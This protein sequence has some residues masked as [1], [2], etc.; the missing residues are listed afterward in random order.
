MSA[1]QIVWFKRDLRTVDHRPLMEAIK[2]GPVLPLYVVEPELWQQPDTSE[3]QWLFCQESLL[4]LQRALAEFGQPLVVRS[5]DVVDVLERARRLFG[6]GALWSHEETG[7]GW[8]YQRDKRVAAWA[9]QQDIPWTEI[10]QFGVTR[11]LKSRNG[12]AKRWEAQMAESLCPSPTSLP[13]MKATKYLNP[14]WYRAITITT[15]SRR[16]N[17]ERTRIVFIEQ[18]VNRFK[19]FPTPVS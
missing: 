7:N 8:T 10:P 5:G 6:I 12:W 4:D 11:R 3:R 15:P 9:K 19:T 16:S 17:S 14:L 2:R 18:L 13:K 1:L